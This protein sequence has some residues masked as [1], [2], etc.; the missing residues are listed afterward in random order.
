MK[1]NDTGDQSQHRGLGMRLMH[2]AERIAREEGYK[3]M[4]VI[5]GVGVR[6]YYRNKLGYTL[7]GTYMVK[8]L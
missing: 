8:K 6:E 3:K 4:A 7:E 5:S 2:E 1:I